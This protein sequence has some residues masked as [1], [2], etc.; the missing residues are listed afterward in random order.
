LGSVEIEEK[1]VL[2]LKLKPPEYR[3]LLCYIPLKQ[4]FNSCFLCTFADQFIN[5]EN[6]E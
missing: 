6:Y 1:I 4:F 5:E 2:L 3:G